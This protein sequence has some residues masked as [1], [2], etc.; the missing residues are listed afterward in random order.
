MLILKLILKIRL[1]V[2]KYY[3]IYYQVVQILIV[4]V[5]TVSV[6]IQIA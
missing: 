6:S 4:P 5:S 2:D 3:L 1:E